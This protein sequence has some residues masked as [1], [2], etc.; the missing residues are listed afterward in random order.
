M[1]QAPK[2]P[3]LP[4]ILSNIIPAYSGS[5]PVSP[6]TPGRLTPRRHDWNRSMS[7]Q[8]RLM[9][10]L[11]S[12]PRVVVALVVVVIVL[13]SLELGF[14]GVNIVPGEGSISEQAIAG[15][16]KTSRFIFVC[17]PVCV[18]PCPERR[19]II[20]LYGEYLGWVLSMS[21]DMLPYL[22]RRVRDNGAS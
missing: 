1:V 20:S 9:G 3:R 16:R 5:S 10:G 14:R 22:R 8:V 21:L 12:L 18:P 2:T 19:L 17:L 7:S 11:T 13:S 15:G 4:R 6:S